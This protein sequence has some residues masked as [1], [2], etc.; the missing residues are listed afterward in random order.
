MSVVNN[1]RVLI[2]DDSDVIAERL[3]AML[4]DIDGLEIVGRASTV[5]GASRAVETLKPDAMILDLQMPGGSGIDVLARMKKDGVTT[6]IV[7]VLT[8]YSHAQYRRKCLESGARFFLDK[9]T[10]FDRVPAVL[11]QLMRD[12]S[13]EQGD[14]S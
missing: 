1:M 14:R 8:N 7:I 5:L 3:A 6:P 12:A 4:A 13:G 9:S 11:N 10:E 2:A